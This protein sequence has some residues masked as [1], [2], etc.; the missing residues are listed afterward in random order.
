MGVG[1]DIAG[2]IRIPSLCCGITGFKPSSRRIPFS[3]QTIPRRRGGF[4]I[5]A[6]V[7]PLCRSIRDMEYFMRSILQF[8]GWTLD[9]DVLSVPW[10][11]RPISQTQ[12]PEMKTFGVM[13]ED[14]KYPLHPSVLRN[15]SAALQKLSAAGH[16]LIQLG[17]ELPK[18]IISSVALTAMT[19]L[20]MDPDKTAVGYVARG[21]EPLVP[22][23]STATL[24]ELA[25]MKPNINGVFNLNTDIN[26]FR[27]MFRQVIVDKNLDGIL[28]PAYQSTA[29]PHDTLGVPSY[30]VL[31][32][33]LDV[34][35]L[36]T[37]I[38]KSLC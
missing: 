5:Q 10:L 8:D 15:L 25:K 6:S 9:E 30:T 35:T 34:S 32:N 38:E 7:G 3:G 26:N 12:M 11:R 28:M 20:G 19:V 2:G 18:D 27:S 21:G 29:V 33:L 17:N 37:L 22:S 24:P 14:P 1:T 4:G 16:K 13:L 23:I 36:S 31:A